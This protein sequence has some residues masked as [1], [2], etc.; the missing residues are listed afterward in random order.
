MLTRQATWTTLAS[1]ASL[2]LT[3]AAAAQQPTP[4]L[5]PLAPAGTGGV[6]IIPASI[7]DTQVA[8]TV[9]GEKITVGEVRKILDSRP[10]PVAAP[11]RAKE[12]DAQRPPLSRSS[13]GVLMRQY[14]T[15]NMPAG[16]AKGRLRPDLKVGDAPEKKWG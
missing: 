16:P 7:P 6:Q 9:N 14:L 5:P 10:L 3:L 4:K 8:A 1:A 15:K 11:R 13:S 12:G 2:L